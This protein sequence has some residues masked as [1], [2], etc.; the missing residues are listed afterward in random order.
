MLK[1]HGQ[2]RPLIREMSSFSSMLS[3]VNCMS[4]S[5]KRVPSV[6]LHAKRFS[7]NF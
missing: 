5:K 2:P 6:L 7:D 3:M 1:S 4:S